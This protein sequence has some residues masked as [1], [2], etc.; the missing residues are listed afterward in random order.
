VI[1]LFGGTGTLG[2]ELTRQLYQKEH[3]VIF[4]RDE[5]KQQEMKREFPDCTYVIGDIRDKDSVNRV[6]RGCDTAYLLAAIKHVDVAESNIVEAVK[7]NF[8]GAVN[9]A[10]QAIERE[11]P[12][13]VFSN[14]DKSVLPITSYGYTKALAGN[15]LLGLNKEDNGTIF[16]A[17]NWGNIVAS[18]GSIIPIFAE[19]LLKANRVKLTD[20]RMSRFWIT[21]EE[22]AS[23]MI[24]NYEEAHRFRSM[25]PPIKAASL[26]RVAT[27]VAKIL[28][29]EYFH[30]DIIGLRC[31]EKLYEVLDTN[32]EKCLRS[33]TCAQYTDRELLDLLRPSVMAV[34]NG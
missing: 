13:V 1:V 18:R 10:E 31:N 19:S 2:R 21:I 6:L 32:H 3:L 7:T 26:L 14:T 34:K 20:S 27:T 17:F 9:V 24:S 28:D 15:Y 11:V 30:T 29:I 33:D 23:F 16:S 22:A 4:S 12:F 5:C 8:L 25:I